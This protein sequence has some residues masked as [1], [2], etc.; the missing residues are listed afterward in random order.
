MNLLQKPSL[1]PLIWMPRGYSRVRRRP[2]ISW[3]A[4]LV[5]AGSFLLTLVGLEVYRVT[6]GGNVH[7]L[8]PHRVYRSAQLSP[9]SL[10]QLIE[11]KQIRTVI[12]LRGCCEPAQW[13]SNQA[14]VI[15]TLGISQEDITLSA[16]RLPPP[17]ELRRLV[18]VLDRSEAPLLIHCRQGADRTGL[19]S[20]M[21]LLLYTDASYWRARWECSPRTG[22]VG[23]GRAA[24]MD[25]FFALYEE[26]LERLQIHHSPAIF[27]DW[28]LHD[29]CPEDCRGELTISDIPSTI[30]VGQPLLLNVQ[31]RNRSIRTWQFRPGTGAGVHARYVIYDPATQEVKIR[32]AGLFHTQ[33]APNESIAIP[34]SFPPFRKPGKYILHIDLID[35]QENAFAQLGNEPIL[36]E[37]NVVDVDPSQ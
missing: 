3:R 31:A 37:L 27:R 16:N 18:E 25:R 26:H 13:Y 2:L 21:I 9:E 8:L 29:Y 12:N 23:I 6:A 35:A 34:L 19:V 15:H 10:Y 36:R 7:R 20:A 28:L 1:R 32:R 24:A 14:K 30:R 5:G 33:V 11:Q 22:H 17:Q 4:L